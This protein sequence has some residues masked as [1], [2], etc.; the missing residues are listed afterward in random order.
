MKL[1]VEEGS[2]DRLVTQVVVGTERECAQAIAL[3]DAI[4]RARLVIPIRERV[5]RRHEREQRARVSVPP[6]RE[7]AAATLC[8]GLLYH[9][10]RIED[11]RLSLAAGHRA[12]RHRFAGHDSSRR[13][14]EPRGIHRRE[15]I[16][17]IDERGREHRW[18]C[19]HVEQERH[20]NAV[21]RIAHV[22]RRGAPHGEIRNAAQDC[23]DP[24]HHLDHPKRVG[25]SARYEADLVARD[26]RRSELLT[27]FAEHG[28]LHGR[29]RRGRRKRQR[30]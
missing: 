13:A 16:D 5:V 28:Y 24:W 20:A 18:T 8:D 3:G 2:A 17:A 26:V 27:P 9:P 30:E 6:A 15:E 21:D 4:G 25:E 7:N 12:R 14:S 29:S 23:R 22:G 19:A 11:A 10:F 1:D